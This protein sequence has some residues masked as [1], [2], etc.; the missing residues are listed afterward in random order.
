MI[1][2]GIGTR[3]IG[4][5]AP[6]QT[7]FAFKSGWFVKSG[8]R[9]LRNTNIHQG[10]LDWDDTV[11]IDRDLLSRFRDFLLNDRDIVLTLDRPIVANGLKVARI[12]ADDLPGFINQRVARF[13]LDSDQ[14]DAAYFYAFL[15][16]PQFIDAIRGHDQSLGVPHISPAQVER[17]ELP[18]PSVFTQRRIAAEL[19]D[20]LASVDAA[21]AAAE[22]R[23]A[24]AEALPAAYLRQVFDASEASGWP[25]LAIETLGDPSRGDT[26]QTGPFGAQ[27][28]SSE[29]KSEGV[30][31]LNIGN[32]KNGVLNLERLDHVTAEKAEDLDRYRLREGDMLFTRSGSVGRSAVVDAGCA[33]WLMSYHLLRVAFD[34]RRVEPGF[35]SAAVRGD[36]AVLS[37]VRHAAGRGATR[38]GINAPILAALKVPVPSLDVQRRVLADLSRRLE[39]SESVAARCREEIGA[40]EALPAAVLRAAFNGDS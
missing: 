11:F 7:G 2:N 13:K 20:S 28:P 39:A 31:V 8:V 9:L 19:N 3:R 5:V 18:L 24:A 34:R 14:L 22:A 38:D 17:V 35:I 15:R 40:V 16:S 32:V 1:A 23:L 36:A 21:R 26:V 30:P 25:R 27:L 29:F 37:Q 33:G 4:E 6:V 10:F 12:V